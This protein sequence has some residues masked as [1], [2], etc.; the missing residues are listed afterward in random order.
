MKKN[1]PF[2]TAEHSKAEY[3]AKYHGS[4]AVVF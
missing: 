3:K 2:K 1:L 4:L